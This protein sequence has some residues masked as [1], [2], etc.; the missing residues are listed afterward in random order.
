MYLN[1]GEF[2]NCARF[3]FL[4]GGGLSRRLTDTNR[5]IFYHIAHAV[6]MVLLQQVVDPEVAAARLLVFF[7]LLMS[8]VVQANW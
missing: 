7:L 8:F 5:S 6:L 4:Q 1:I 2:A 3:L